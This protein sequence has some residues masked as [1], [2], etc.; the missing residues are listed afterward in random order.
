[1]YSPGPH[2]HSLMQL[3]FLKIVLTPTPYIHTSF[4]KAYFHKSHIGIWVQWFLFLKDTQVQSILLVQNIDLYNIYDIHH[5]K[6]QNKQ[7]LETP[8]FPPDNFFC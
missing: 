4:S 1:M 6:K 8:F 3:F 2:T 5:V 7:S